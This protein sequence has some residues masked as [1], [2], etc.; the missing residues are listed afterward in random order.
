LV[1]TPIILHRKLSAPDNVRRA[2][3]R[4]WVK[5]WAEASAKAGIPI[6][7]KMPSDYGLTL[8]LPRDVADW[9]TDLTRKLRVPA[10]NQR[11]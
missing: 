3:H 8:S 2:R 6:P 7:K 1:E 11:P 5:H 10:R 4:R 9:H